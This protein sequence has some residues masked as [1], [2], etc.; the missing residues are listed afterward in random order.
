MCFFSI[1]AHSGGRGTIEVEGVGS[2][3]E[4]SHLSLTFNYPEAKPF[5]VKRNEDEDEDS[6][7]EKERERERE[8][9]RV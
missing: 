7:R 9:E 1:L 8:R 3:H 5:V 4:K 6:R 2:E